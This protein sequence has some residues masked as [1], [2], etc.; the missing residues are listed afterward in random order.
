MGTQYKTASDIWSFGCLLAE[1]VF[2]ECAS[3]PV[4]TVLA[5][6]EGCM[7]KTGERTGENS[8]PLTLLVCLASMLTGEPLFEGESPS[9][10]VH[11][12]FDQVGNP[13]RALVDAMRDRVAFRSII[14]KLPDESVEPCTFPLMER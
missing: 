9:E 13:P 10:V 5:A 14:S 1:M 7:S 4:S 12:I 6:G 2:G 11:A 3:V 8:M